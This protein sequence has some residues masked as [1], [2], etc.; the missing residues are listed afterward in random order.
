MRP[1]FRAWCLIV[2]S[3]GFLN[4]SC[5]NTEP[6]QTSVQKT[7]QP[8]EVITLESY[9]LPVTFGALSDVHGHEENLD[10]LLSAMDSSYDI[11][12]YV[13]LGDYVQYGS[14][15][16]KNGRSPF[17]DMVQTMTSVAAYETPTI[18]LPGNHDFRN[19]YEDALDTVQELFPFL[20]DGS[21][22]RVLR[23]PAFTI[24]TS[25]HGDDYLYD[26]SGFKATDSTNSAL[27]TYLDEYAKTATTLVLT[28]QPPYSPSQSGADRVNGANVGSRY[29]ADL[30]EEY[31][32]AY[33][34]AGHI[35][36]ASGNT[37]SF[38]Q[39]TQ[40][41]TTYRRLISNVSSVY[42]E[43]QTD[44][45][46]ARG[47]TATVFILDEEGIQYHPVGADTE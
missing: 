33:V 6:D 11:D 13:L 40:P 3:L 2:A 24:I 39:P 7:A 15:R 47:P 1:L 18:V 16:K 30:I 38:G 34:L 4:T 5:T 23:H 22:T 45:T 19:V 28:H 41:N 20:I 29:L 37:T 9:M 44:T 27:E 21:R 17:E 8:Q 42:S 31:E 43:R 36:T 10:T 25:P 14:D 26:R 32:I 12:F 46:D 35:H